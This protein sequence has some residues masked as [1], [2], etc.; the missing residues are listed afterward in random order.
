MITGRHLKPLKDFVKA[1]VERYKEEV[2]RIVDH[3]RMDRETRQEVLRWRENFEARGARVTKSVTNRL[4]SIRPP[5]FDCEAPPPQCVERTFPRPTLQ[6]LF[7]RLF[8]GRTPA[9]IRD[10][11]AESRR[12][13]KQFTRIMKRLPEVYQRCPTY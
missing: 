3:T 11:R 6:Y 5:V 1:S 9:P 4:N 8:R 13:Q 10:L 12:D 7:S 2:S